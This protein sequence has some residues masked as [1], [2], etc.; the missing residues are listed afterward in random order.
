[1][2]EIYSASKR[3]GC[4]P[5]MP[6][7]AACASAPPVSRDAG[8]E[9]FFHR[10]LDIVNPLQH[11]PLI[12][13][14]YRA[15]SGDQIGTV[16]KIAGDALYGGLWGAVCSLADAGFESLTGKSLE[17]SALALFTTPSVS[18]STLVSSTALSRTTLSLPDGAPAEL[19]QIKGQTAPGASI[20]QSAMAS[21][22]MAQSAP[23][24][25]VVALATAL[26]V[27]GV[28]QETAGRALYAYQRS[29]SMRVPI[30]SASAQ[31]H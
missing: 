10:L 5:A 14:L 22:Q 2:E 20:A 28:N 9:D 29:L 18:H 21:T 26:S 8:D 6:A 4:V 12:G 11:L 17:D 13:T 24:S 16:E 19:P 25:D 15:V 23:S 7:T 31:I 3:A 30:A 27:K 1:M